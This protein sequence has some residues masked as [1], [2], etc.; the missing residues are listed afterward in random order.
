MQCRGACERV[1]YA[2]EKEMGLHL[3][4]PGNKEEITLEECLREGFFKGSFGEGWN[5]PTC[6]KKTTLER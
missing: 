1:K 5:C 3:F 2:S 6:L 4:I